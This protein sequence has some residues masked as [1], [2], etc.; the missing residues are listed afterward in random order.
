MVADCL[1]RSG[2]AHDPVEKHKCTCDEGKYQ[3][4]DDDPVN[5]VDN[6]RDCCAHFDVVKIG[7]D[8]LGDEWV[9][10]EVSGADFAGVAVASLEDH[11]ELGHDS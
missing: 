10:N 4:D 5:N 3:T 8:P 11:N 9:V 7:I 1:D 2:G 6:F